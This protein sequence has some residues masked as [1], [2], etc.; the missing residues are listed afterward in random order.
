MVSEKYDEGEGKGDPPKGERGGKPGLMQDNLCSDLRGAGA[1][2]SHTS[3]YSR[4]GA[5][6]LKIFLRLFIYLKESVCVSGER[7]RGGG[8]GRGK[9][10]QADSMLSMEPHAGL[11]LTTVRS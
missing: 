10:S 7:S 11:D 2:D 4:L 6:K 5:H 8:R 3:E 9:E 1:S